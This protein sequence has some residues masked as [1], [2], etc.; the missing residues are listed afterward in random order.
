[1]EDWLQSSLEKKVDIK[2]LELFTFDPNAIEEQKFTQQI[3]C[4]IEEEYL[5]SSERNLITDV[6]ESKD[7]AK[8]PENDRKYEKRGISSNEKC[9]I[10]GLEFGNKK[11]LNIHYSFVHPNEE[12]HVKNEIVID[13][14][15]MHKCSICT[16]EA[17]N[18]T[19]LQRHIES[20]H[21]GKKNYVCSI[22]NG[23]CVCLPNIGMPTANAN[24]LYC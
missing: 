7:I 23:D 22:C 11:V 19:Y 10:C 8:E 13:K 18:R 4:K 21:E 6:Q 1:M 17:K 12:K 24:G 14:A 20:F 9:Q 2:N 15:S 16:Y 5:N 3:T